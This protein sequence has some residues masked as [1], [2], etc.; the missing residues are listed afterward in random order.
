MLVFHAC[1]KKKPLQLTEP[2][3]KNKYTMLPSSFAKSVSL[4]AT[5]LLALYLLNI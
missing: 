5:C 1:K 4:P 3:I 2:V